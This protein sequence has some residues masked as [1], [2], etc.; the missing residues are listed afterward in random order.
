[1][2]L[3]YL[4]ESYDKVEYWLTTLLVPAD[5]ALKLQQD[6]DSIVYEAYPGGYGVH[7]SAELHGHQILHGLGEWECMAPKVRARIGIYR[8]AFEA[9]AACEGIEIVMRGIRIPRQ[10]E[11]YADPWHPHRV[12]IDFM[13]QSLNLM[14]KGR[15]T[16]FLA[17]ADEI[18]QADTLRASYWDFQYYGTLS[19]WPG[20]INRS[21]DTLHFA[22]SKYSRLLQG[23][24]LVSYL[25]FRMRRSKVIDP[26]ALKVNNDLW[27]IIATKLKV[28]HIWP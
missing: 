26:R 23:A 15:D 22:P 17:I 27:N 18:D 16:H 8:K 10:K 20:K 13:A 21:L 12:A 3:A 9:I 5:A 4:D 1:M 6:L 28:H 2:L 24:D 25:H 14:S 7:W 19:P 11:R